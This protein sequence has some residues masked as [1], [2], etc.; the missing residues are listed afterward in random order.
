MNSSRCLLTF[1]SINSGHVERNPTLIALRNICLAGDN[2]SAWGSMMA[3][4]IL[5][6]WYTF[7]MGLAYISL[8]SRQ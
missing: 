2:K 5:A 3:S 4:R 7:W 8:F 1:S 6:V